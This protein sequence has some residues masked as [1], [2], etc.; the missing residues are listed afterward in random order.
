MARDKFTEKEKLLEAED[1]SGSSFDAVLFKR[2]VAFCKPYKWQFL[3]ALL[4]LFVLAATNL[5]IPYITKI[6]IDNGI[7][8]K[9]MTIISK[10]SIIFL[11]S[12]V[13]RYV[14]QHYQTLLFAATA[15]K[16]TNDIRLALF[17]HIQSMSISFFNKNEIGRLISRLM[18]DV[19]A[20]NALIVQGLLTLVVD[21][22]TAVGVI[23]IMWKLNVTLTLWILGLLPIVVVATMIFS[24]HARRSY[25]DVRK[26]YAT[27]TGAISENITGVKVV[28]SFAREKSNLLNYKRANRE[29]RRS[30]MKSV[31]VGAFFGM[32]VE[33]ITFIGMT[34]IFIV[35]GYMVRDALLTVGGFVAF[36]AYI[37]R[38]LAPIR[39][40]TQFYNVMQAAMAGA[41]RIFGIL[42]TKSDIVDKENALVLKDIE[43]EVEFKNVV[44]GYDENIILNDVSFKVEAG[45]TVAFVGP[46]GAGKSTIINLLARQ[47]DIKSGV[48]TVDGIDIRDVTVKSLRENTGVVLQDSFLFMGTIMD[49]IRYGRLSATDKEVI[50]AAKTVGVYD[51]IMELPKGFKT[52]IRE[53]SANLSTGQ[54]QLLSFARALIADPK[55]LVLDEATSSVDTQTEKLIQYA[56][57]QLFKNRTSFVVAHRLSTISEADCIYVI[58]GGVIRE[59][60]THDE[61]MSIEDGKYREL[62]NIQFSKFK[63]V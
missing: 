9:D 18:S 33:T 63:E 42:D 50:E 25:R 57:K 19:D 61:L 2:A 45:K 46:T 35:G 34:V 52:E 62:Y 53:G 55:I 36:L 43:G 22:L 3:I 38:F 60:G 54:K 51:F 13:L 31:S 21:V 44:F 11:V 30:I 23:F 17:S 20:L 7:S 41:E 37:E 59:H 27:S 26:K 14:F 1:K 32:T 4:L 58:D 12:I 16:I 28:K 15:Q 8:A 49:N 5:L 6:I 48:I 40:I 47:F 56:L 39:N 24:K 10:W 29:L